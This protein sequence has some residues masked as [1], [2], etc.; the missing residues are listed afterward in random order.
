[1]TFIIDDQQGPGRCCVLISNDASGAPLAGVPIY[2]F[3]E[4]SISQV[5]TQTVTTTSIPLGMLA[6]DHCG[7]LSWDL[8]PLRRQIV[9]LTQVP[10]QRP[11]TAQVNHIWLTV[12]GPL[13]S[14]VDALKDAAIG[15]EAIVTQLSFDIGGVYTDSGMGIP[16]MQSPSL[17]DWYLSPG[18]F[19]HMPAERRTRRLRSATSIQ[20]SKSEFSA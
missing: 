15:V 4:A 9:A 16:S 5:G 11:G 20:C 7:Y 2:A 6:S 12:Y 8:E 13:E 1:M 18:S 3:A 17:V 14:V 10:A 19:A